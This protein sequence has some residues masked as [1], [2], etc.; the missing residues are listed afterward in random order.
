MPRYTE[1]HIMMRYAIIHISKMD[2]LF[3]F[4]PQ[5]GSTIFLSGQVGNRPETPTQLVEGGLIA[6]ATQIFN[7]LGYVLKVS[8]LHM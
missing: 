3:I 6:E 2:N 7:N 1:Q 5:V 8:S 4:P